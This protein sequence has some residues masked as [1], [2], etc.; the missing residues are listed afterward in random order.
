MPEADQREAPDELFSA[1]GAQLSKLIRHEYSML[2]V[3]NS[4]SGQ[5][6]LY[7]LHSMGL[8]FIDTLKGPFD[9]SG[10]PA[11]EVLATGKPVVA[12]A[13]DIERQSSENLWRWDSG[14]FARFRWSLRIEPLVRWRFVE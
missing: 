10:L 13:T 5:L 14:P 9:P 7:A 8:P 4:D 1:I 3:S 12:Y 11:S 6:D 2:T